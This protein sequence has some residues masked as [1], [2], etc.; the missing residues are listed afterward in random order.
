MEMKI[1]FVEKSLVIIM[2]VA[3]LVVF[4]FAQRDTEKLFELHAAG[5]SAEIAD[6]NNK[7]TTGFV[8]TRNEP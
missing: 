4:S 7:L 5:S 6:D 2:F 1:K 3:V 8:H